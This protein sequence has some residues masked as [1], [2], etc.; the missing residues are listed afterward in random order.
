MERLALSFRFTF[1][2]H[3]REVRFECDRGQGYQRVFPETFSFHG[4]HH[5]PAELFFQLDD[6]LNRP[7]LLSPRANRRD[8]QEL[9]IRLLSQVPQYLEALVDDLGTRLAEAPMLRLYQDMALFCE[10][11]SR[12]LTSRELTEQRRSRVA[13]LL[14]RKL[15]YRG[16]RELVAGRVTPEYLEQYIRGEVD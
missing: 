6:L 14:M 1:A 9:V 4:D 8:S 10:I 11:S 15:I 7:E 16:L 2:F 3:A 5:D 13:I 12:F